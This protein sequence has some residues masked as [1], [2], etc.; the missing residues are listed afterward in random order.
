MLNP[1]GS[2]EMAAGYA[3]DRPRMHA[4]V[5]SRVELALAEHLPF[6][7][8]LDIGCGAGLSTA[9]LPTLARHSIGVDPSAAMLATSGVIAPDAH[10]V[11]ARAEQLPVASASIDLVTAAGSLNYTRVPDA[12]AEIHR[13]LAPEGMLVVYDW[14][15]ARR[16][17]HGEVLDNW[18]AEFRRR[19]PRPP[20]EAIPLDPAT[21]GDH[22][23][24]LRLIDS[25]LFTWPLTMSVDEYERYML[26]ETNVAAAVRGGTPLEEIR[27]WCRET[28]AG[29]FGG[30]L[31]EVLFH[32]Y[33]AYFIRVED[34]DS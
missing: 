28:L 13:V 5:L 19:Y 15:T 23:R 9:P 24:A 6:G 26:T 8:A 30:Q 16:F 32:G 27:Q 11:A 7:R 17:I 25:R 20:S 22:T 34:C 33:I 14:S 10:F 12:L 2:P 31:R 3:A 21:I 18:F 1:F 4:R 29:I